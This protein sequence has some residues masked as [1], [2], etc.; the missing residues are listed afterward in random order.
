MNLRGIWERVGIRYD[1]HYWPTS[2][3]GSTA[4]ARWSKTMSEYGTEVNV[5]VY[6]P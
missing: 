6:K 1:V 5:L 2:L 4:S 3:Q